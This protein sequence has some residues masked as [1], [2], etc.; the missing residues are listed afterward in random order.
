MSTAVQPLLVTVEEFLA[1]EPPAMD[2]RRRRAGDR[3][4]DAVPA[5][6]RVDPT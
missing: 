3:S 2:R 5:Q 6:N 4:G 1:W